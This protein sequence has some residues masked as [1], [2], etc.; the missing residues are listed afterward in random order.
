MAIGFLCL[1]NVFVTVRFIAFFSIILRQHCMHLSGL[2]AQEAMTWDRLQLSEPQR[3][4]ER[5]N[6]AV[7]QNAQFLRFCLAEKQRR[8][9]FC[10]ILRVRAV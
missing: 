5:L 10:G 9:Q 4:R 3:E 1:P 7:L 8:G 2:D 6:F